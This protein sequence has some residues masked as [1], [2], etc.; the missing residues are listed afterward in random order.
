MKIISLE[1]KA[2]ELDSKAARRFRNQ[3][4]ATL[5]SYEYSAISKVL[6]NLDSTFGT[7]ILVDSLKVYI[8][9][10]DRKLKKGA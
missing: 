4:D 10:L 6:G 5:Y 2:Y 9:R 8:D 7:E 1:A 3:H